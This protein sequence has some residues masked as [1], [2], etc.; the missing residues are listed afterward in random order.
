[1]C[2]K[3]QDES[4]QTDL[5][6]AEPE[7]TG[8]HRPQP[9]GLELKP[10]QEEKQR[11]T[12]LGSTPHVLG[13]AHETEAPRAEQHAGGEIA[14]NATEP[15]PLEKRHEHDNRKKKRRGKFEKMH[16]LSVQRCHHKRSAR[17]RLHHSFR[18]PPSEKC[19]VPSMPRIAPTP[20]A[21]SAARM[22]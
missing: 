12:Q 3:R 13:F 6:A 21:A 4:G 22:P 1:M 9:R 14:K 11:D 2:N 8:S 17:R 20:A 5:R 15:Q 16:L 19:H 7:H 18:A 10:H